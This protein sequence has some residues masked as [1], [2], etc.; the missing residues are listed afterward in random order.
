[1]T[2]EELNKLVIGRK[3]TDFVLLLNKYGY[4]NLRIKKENINEESLVKKVY[5]TD[6]DLINIIC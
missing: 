6:D 4:T 2:I 5:F 1:M 3:L